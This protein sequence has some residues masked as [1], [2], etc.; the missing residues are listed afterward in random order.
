MIDSKNIFLDT[1]PIVYYLENKN[2]K[3]VGSTNRLII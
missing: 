3:N 1:A 2:V